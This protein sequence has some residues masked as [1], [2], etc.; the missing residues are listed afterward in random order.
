[1]MVNAGSVWGGVPF[2]KLPPAQSVVFRI[3]H[4]HLREYPRAAM[5]SI[6]SEK[7]RLLLEYHQKTDS[8]SAAV[9]DLVNQVGIV[10]RTEYDRLDRIVEETRRG[11]SEAQTLFERHVEDHHC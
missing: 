6:C 11:S 10:S 9:S 8:Y 4:L 1:M 5:A 7:M 3:F 2:T